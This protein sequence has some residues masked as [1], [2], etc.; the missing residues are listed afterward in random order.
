[1][2]DRLEQLF[3]DLRSESL[4]RLV[5]PG[6]D[7]A[8]RTARRRRAA[9]ASAGA[10]VAVT[11]VVSG[12]LLLGGH[13]PAPAPAAPPPSSAE[14][15][16]PQPQ[17]DAVVESRMAVAGDALGDPNQ[18]PYIMSTDGV[19]TAD[20]E[21][22]VNDIPAGS[23]HLFVYCAG[24]GK[25]DLLVK[26]EMYGNRKLAAGTVTCSERPVPGKFAVKQPYDG[27]LRV[28]LHGDEQAAGHAAFSF[29]FV[30]DG[31]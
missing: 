8:R 25:I 4:N 9:A 3:A 22:D 16:P 1:M 12:A 31:S 6:P 24:T 19:V 26:A 20:Y 2:T 17:P 23:Y 11:A 30:R 18:H 7:Q 15:F 29:K 5:P 21:D 14:L 13:P 28:F 27:Y 10:A